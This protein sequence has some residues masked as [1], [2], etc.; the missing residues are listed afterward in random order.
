[1]RPDLR[2]SASLFAVLLFLSLPALLPVAA[3]AAPASGRRAVIVVLEDGAGDPGDVA[4]Q[5]GRAYGLEVGPVYRSV[6]GG[7]AASV[8]TA[9]LDALRADASVLMVAPDEPVSIAKRIRRLSTQVLPTGVNRINADSTANRG[10]GVDVAVLDTGIDSDHPDL[11]P[12]LAGGVNCSSGTTFEDGN[13]HGTHVAG[14]IAA[15][16]NRF[17]VV[18]VAPLANLWAVRVLNNAGSGSTSS[19]VCGIDFVDSLSPAHGGPITVAN[20]SLGGSGS[21]DGACGT[22]NGDPMHAAICAATADGVTFVVAAGNDGV[23]LAGSV[24]AA[25]DE[26]VTV[27]A[28]ADSDGRSCGL[29]SPTGYG[30]DDTFA[31]FSNTGSGADLDHVVAAPGVGI[32]STYKNAGYASLSGTSM[33]T[34][35]VAGAAALYIAGHPG[36]GASEVLASLRTTGELPGVDMNGECSGGASHTDAPGQ[37]PEPVVR[38]EAF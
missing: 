7:Y 29:G 25:Y 34:P 30:V 28:L 36:A 35:H 12:N 16:A 2:A 14:T 32:Y 27:T 38:A 31:S 11:A 26:V 1:M 9:R 23:N 6:F 33:A 4:A 17:G 5:H 22:S 10:Y 13:G 3:T 37:H 18:G 24:P 19:V 15:R 8:P 20:M 21:D